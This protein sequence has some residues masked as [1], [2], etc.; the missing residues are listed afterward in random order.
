MSVADATALM[1]V[2]INN[3]SFAD[4]GST[5]GASEHDMKLDD[6]TH[7]VVGQV[8]SDTCSSTT[9]G[10]S[11][12]PSAESDFVDA[13]GVLSVFDPLLGSEDLSRSDFELLEAEVERWVESYRRPPLIDL[14]IYFYPPD[15]GFLHF[16]ERPDANGDFTGDFIDADPDDIDR[17]DP[18]LVKRHLPTYVFPWDGRVLH[19]TEHWHSAVAFILNQPLLEAALTRTTT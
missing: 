4:T 18:E 3:E 12:G 8:S 11:N 1:E 2:E 19:W 17:L 13:S 7:S 9:A 5:A 14:G 6:T 10:L 15:A 16:D